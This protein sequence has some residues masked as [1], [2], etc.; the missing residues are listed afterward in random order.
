MNE[1]V[2]CRCGK[3]SMNYEVIGED[4]WTAT[5]TNTKI[6]K[7]GYGGRDCICKSCGLI[8]DDFDP[9]MVKGIEHKKLKTEWKS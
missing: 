7:N 9:C 8:Y 5:A 1:I 6:N 4:L 2:T 3:A